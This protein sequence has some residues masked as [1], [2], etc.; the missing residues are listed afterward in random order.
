MKTFSRRIGLCFCILLAGA[1]WAAE[2]LKDKEEGFV[3]LFD[4]KS[5]EG[6]R[7]A[8]APGHGSGGLWSVKNGAIDAV[9]QSPG[10]WSMLAT[11]KEYGDFELRLEVRTDWPIDAGVLLRTTMEAHAYAI[12]IQ[13]R[14]DGDVGGI[15]LSKIG[16]FQVPAKDWKKA[17]KKDGWNEVRILVKGNPPEIRT[18]INGMPM[19]ESKVELKDA[20][21]GP[22]G[23]VALEIR[24]PENCFYN[25]VAFRNI[26]ILERDK[27]L[28][29]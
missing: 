9:Q 21:V 27:K 19:A 15:A 10:A 17:W 22:A 24:G 3:P 5:L 4:G 12:P 20:R 2:V 18:W 29:D 28:G 7:A 16:D 1:L 25:H 26:R 11:A 14:P 13:S 8:N 6:W 23:H